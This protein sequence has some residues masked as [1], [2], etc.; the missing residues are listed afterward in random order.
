MKLAT[1]ENETK[2]R[3]VQLR[4]PVC[5]QLLSPQMEMLVMWCEKWLGIDTSDR[6]PY[7]E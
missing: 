2:G 6:F 4:D 3:L 5:T 1:Q 7:M